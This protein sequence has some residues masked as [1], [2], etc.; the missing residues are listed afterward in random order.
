ML[1]AWL[2]QQAKHKLTIVQH[3]HSHTEVAKGSLCTNMDR[4][5]WQRNLHK[6]YRREELTTQVHLPIQHTP[7]DSSA[8]EGEAD[9][10]RLSNVVSK[11]RQEKARKEKKRNEKKRK[12]RT[13]QTR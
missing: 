9:A 8:T 2:L 10:Y 1:G 13:E 5:T 4:Q 11:E 6:Q 7:V 12:K 3:H